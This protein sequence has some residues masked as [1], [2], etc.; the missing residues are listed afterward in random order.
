MHFLISC[1]LE[2]E[3]TLLVEMMI[4]L[5]SMHMKSARIFDLID[6]STW[7]MLLM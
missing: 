7:L 1:K 4:S 3:T 5:L 6:L 2:E